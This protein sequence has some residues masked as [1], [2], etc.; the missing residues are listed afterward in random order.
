MTLREQ[1]REIVEETNTPLGRG[2]DITIQCLIIVGVVCFVLETESALRVY[3]FFF[4]RIE[5]FI[6][7]T[8][9][10]EYML[11][12]W[13]AKN[14][15]EYMRSGWG[16]VDFLAIAPFYLGI[17]DLRILRILRI[18]RLLRVFKLARYIESLQLMG[19]VF[20]QVAPAL[21]SFS[22][23]VSI[24]ILLSATGIYYAE[25]DAQP[26]VFSSISSCLWWSVV[27]LTTV[28]YGDAYPIT[29]T[30]KVF[31]SIVMLLGIG[32]VAVPIALLSS[33]FTVAL[34]KG[35]LNGKETEP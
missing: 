29:A 20:R 26:K 23:I 35:D 14:R 30:G 22:M 10:A 7:V 19:K 6:V 2:F 32:I 5:V 31:A 27:T 33:A 15:W 16:I 3:K 25:H 18:F 13:S 24:T 21:T 1:I 9:T 12:V 28:G 8:F 11:R 17:G 4:H 34:S